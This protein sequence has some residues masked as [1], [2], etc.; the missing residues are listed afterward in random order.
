[1]LFLSTV[2][3]KQDIFP[4]ESLL[5]KNKAKKDLSEK[6]ATEKAAAKKVCSVFFQKNAYKT[7]DCFKRWQ[8][9]RFTDLI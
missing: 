1:M 7:F 8:L 3:T 6:A 2:P 5:K 9:P 4:P